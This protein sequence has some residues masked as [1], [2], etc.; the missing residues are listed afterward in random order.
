MNDDRRIRVLTTWYNNGGVLLINYDQFRSLLAPGRLRSDTYERLLLDPSLVVLDESH[1]I[2]NSTSTIATLVKKFKTHRRLC[3]TG[4][5]LQNNM[6]EYYN[7]LKFT[8]P[9]LIGNPQEFK[10]TYQIPIESVYA[11]SSLVQR[12]QAK[13]KLFELQL[14]TKWVIHRRDASILHREL[15]GITEYFITCSLTDIQLKLYTKFLEAVQST[16]PNILVD[17]TVLRSICAH[18]AVFQ[19]VMTHRESSPKGNRRVLKLNQKNQDPLEADDD[20]LEGLELDEALTVSKYTKE[21]PNYFDWA[22]EAL[23]SVD[24]VQDWHLSH[25]MAIVFAICRL[26]KERDEKL[27]IVSHSLATLD[28]IQMMLITNFMASFRI[29]GSTVQRDRQGILDRFNDNRGVSILLLSSRAGGIGVNITAASRMILVD[30][31]WN[32]SYDQQSIGRVYRFGQKKHVHIYHLMTYST[33]E[34]VMMAKNKHKLGIASRVV[35]NKI[36]AP[37]MKK[38]TSTY[39]QTP[40]EAPSPPLNS[41]SVDNVQD[42]IMRALLDTDDAAI[43]QLESSSAS[44]LPTR[45]VSDIDSDLSPDEYQLIR[46]KAKTALRTAIRQLEIRNRQPQT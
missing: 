29:D 15:A 2:K 31:D 20:D 16:S 19:K 10:S 24:F 9:E 40:K 12:H 6:I 7:M 13:L 41:H 45:H 37:M 3:L 33:V 30:L 36:A 44:N 38:D 1:R 14:I 42:D 46:Q 8:F 35:D 39:Y 32:P 17:L 11:D 28:F 26:T 22:K 18:P 5:P 23:S 27:V 25:K 34:T 43:V 4:Y 21:N